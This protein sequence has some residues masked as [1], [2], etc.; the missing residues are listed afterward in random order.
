M[1][2]FFMFGVDGSF[3]ADSV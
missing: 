1:F 2:N 3:I